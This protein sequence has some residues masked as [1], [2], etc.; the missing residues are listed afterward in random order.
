M[1]MN[2]VE[3]FVDASCIGNPGTIEY[4]GLDGSGN[5]LF[6]EKYPLGTNN[7]AEFL[8]L[9]DGYK[10]I[11]ENSDGCGIVW[12]DSTTAISWFY[13]K[14]IKTTLPMNH[15]TEPLFNK[16]S[17]AVD[18]LRRTKSECKIMKWDT[19]DF[20]EIP[21]DYGRKKTSYGNKRYF[22]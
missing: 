2:E 9:V 12:T 7:I 15:Y 1:Q 10:W 13:R 14:R 11:N 3:I 17:S 18:Y 4:R 22:F 16:I 5:V 6:K 21:A 19:K 8:A 20:G